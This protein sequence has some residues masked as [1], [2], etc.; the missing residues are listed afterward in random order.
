[1]NKQ[2]RK[3]EELKA[4]V[5]RLRAEKEILWNLRADQTAPANARLRINFALKR[6]KAG[7]PHG[8]EPRPGFPWFK[9][10]TRVQST[11]ERFE[12]IRKWG[13]EEAG[14]KPPEPEVIDKAFQYL[15]SLWSVT[16]SLWQPSVFVAD[17]DGTPGIS[18]EWIMN[19]V[20]SDIEVFD[21]EMCIKKVAIHQ[22]P[23]V[24]RTFCGNPLDLIAVARWI[25]SE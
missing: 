1:M 5:E 18:L 7:I 10:P 16:P 19:G 8:W 25:T 9:G 24:T 21:N 2:I 23:L 17:R 3:I 6:C 15:I 20:S 4:E 14:G 22:R 12:E 13:P 11:A